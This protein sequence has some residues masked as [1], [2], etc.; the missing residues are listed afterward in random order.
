MQWMKDHHQNRSQKNGYKKARHHVIE[1]Q[2]Y[3]DDDGN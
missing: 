3:D 1:Q 2:T